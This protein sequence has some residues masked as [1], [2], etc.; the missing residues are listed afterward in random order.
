MIKAFL[1]IMTYLF[2]NKSSLVNAVNLWT[3][4]NNQALNLYGEI[5]SWNVSSISDFSN[6]FSN[7]NSFNSNISN[8][9]VSSGNNFSNMFQGASSF[10]QDISNWD[11]SSGNNFSNMFKNASTFDKNLSILEQHFTYKSY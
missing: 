1:L 8:W 6:L 2:I 3:L 9:D 11:V 4:D 5:N 7:N 10:N